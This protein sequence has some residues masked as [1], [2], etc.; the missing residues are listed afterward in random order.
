MKKEMKADGMTAALLDWYAANSRDLPWRRTKEPYRIWL[1]EI[2]A[3]QTRIAALLP[4]YERFVERFPDVFALARAGEAEV[5]KYWEGL[6]YYSRARMLHRTAGIV[7]AEMD[8]VFPKTAAELRKLPGIGDYTAGAIA[9][10]CYNER[11]P[12]VDGNVLRVFARLRND[13]SDVVRPE[14]KKV[15]TAYLLDIMPREAGAFNQAAMEL[16]A[17]VCVPKNP[18]CAECPVSDFCEARRGGREKDLPIKAKK[19]PRK[20]QD[21]TVLLVINEAGEILVRRRTERLLQGL[22]EYVLAEGYVD[23]AEMLQAW[24]FADAAIEDAGRAVHVF[25]H[26]EWHMTGCRCAVQGRDAPKGYEFVPL[27]VLESLALPSALSAFTAIV[28]R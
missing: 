19:P 6:G 14:T 21:M 5:L 24:G 12:A 25:T 27:A 11:V 20:V 9:S 17:L 3:Q 22:W 7:A 4:F 26:L 15:L 16:G 13:E 2:M 1:S 8:G 28:I 23:A 10:I 18:R